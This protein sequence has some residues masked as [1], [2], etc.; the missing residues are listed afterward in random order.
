MDD[1]TRMRYHDAFGRTGLGSVAAA[2]LAELI[3]LGGDTA[4]IIASTFAKRLGVSR[5]T[6]NAA[7]HQMVAKGM[8]ARAGKVVTL[9]E[10]Q[11]WK[12]R[13]CKSVRRFF[14]ARSHVKMSSPPAVP[15]AGNG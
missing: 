11:S 8:I 7:L 13:D 10:P 3:R 4:P 15:I 5:N 1:A 2:V 9:L 12:S 6:V 14:P